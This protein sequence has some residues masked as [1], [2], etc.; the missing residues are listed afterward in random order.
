LFGKS[1]RHAGAWSFC[2]NILMVFLT[3]LAEKRP[4]TYLKK[5]TQKK[6]GW[7]VGGSGI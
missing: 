1:F 3:P 6:V 5:N 2:K 7:W 4:K